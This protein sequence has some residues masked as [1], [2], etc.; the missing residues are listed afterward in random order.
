[1][2]ETIGFIKNE[3]KDFVPDIA[4]VLGSACGDFAQSL[5]GIEIDYSQIPNFKSSSVKGHLGKLLFCEY[6]NKNL[7]IAQGRTHFYEGHGMS[8]VVFPIKVFKKLG[9]KTLILTNAAGSASR[10]MKPADIM[11]IKDH[12]NF[13]GTNPLIGRNDDTLG[14]R[15]PDMTDVYTPSLREI[16]K[17]CAK[18]LNINIKEGVYLATTGPSYE[19]PSEVK[20]FSLLGA[21]VIGMSTVPEAIVAKHCGLEVLGISVITNYCTGISDKPL[22]HQEV[23]ETGKKASADIKNL[24]QETVKNIQVR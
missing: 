7:L 13:M 19:T 5:K 11:I 6:G 4:L 23:V 22:S 18:K 17:K 20:M 2:E 24:L 1:M 16:C 8:N 9:V 21:D 12:I 10:K 14:T 3:I 15:F